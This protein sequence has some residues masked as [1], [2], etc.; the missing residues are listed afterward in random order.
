MNILVR[1]NNMGK[2]S[3]KFL[4]VCEVFDRLE[5]TSSRNDMTTILVDLFAQISKEEGQILSYLI[6]GRIAPLF[7]QSEFG[8]SE[9]SLLNSLDSMIQVSESKISLKEKRNELGDIGDTVEFVS[10]ELSVKTKS[11]TLKRVYEMLWDIASQEGSGS[12]E[13]KS[14]VVVEAIQ[15]MSALE[16]KYFS[17]I[18]CGSLRFG[19]NSK[20]LLDVF[21]FLIQGDKGMRSVLDRG[22]GVCPDIGY[23][24][25]LIDVDSP[26]E[27]KKKISSLR[28]TPG[29]PVLPRLVER[30]K[31]FEE[32]F[33]RL[34][35][36]ILVQNKYDG[37]R[38][39]IHKFEGDGIVLRDS[40]WSNYLPKE[41]VN[42]LFGG[43]EEVGNVRLFTRNLEDVTEM[44]PELVESAMG[45][46]E[47]SFVL[48]SEVLGWDKGSSEFLS[49]QETMQRRRKHGVSNLSSEV[50]VKAMVFDVLFLNGEDLSREDTSRRVDRIRSVDTPTGIEVE[51]TKS[52][53]DVGSLEELFANSIEDG[54]EG[55]IVKKLEGSY[56][57]GVRNYEWIKLKKS[58]G[59]KVVDTIDLVAVG[60]SY[61]SGRRSDFGVGSV[62][63]AVYNK[64][65]GVFE[66]VCNVGTGFSDDQLKHISKVL[67]GISLKGKPKDVET[68]KSLEPDVWV[69]PKFVFT[70]EADE[71]TKKKD[72]EFLSLRFPR[73]V[74]WGRDKGATEATS[75]RELVSMFKGS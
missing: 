43:V 13:R 18:V 26:E 21:S 40:V 61:G 64:E 12:V 10:K 52:V 68:Q 73:L 5:K 23:I 19:L 31:S 1:S 71:I 7:V 30:V 58:M 63:G 4:E 9:K 37:L 33:E 42:T 28:V 15:G 62:L 25:S 49:F 65:E 74:E 50:P 29:V 35:E 53:E 38:C 56:L 66:S 47:K 14:R 6:E 34:G 20:T 72:T 11:M 60:Y 22:Y 16:A 57:P 54:F 41:E 59:K 3:I 27:T 70:V 45:M 2:K 48:D 55:L 17:R 46:K 44:F 69:R 39:Q 32:V 51:D 36:E 24:Y 67:E 75:K 8:F